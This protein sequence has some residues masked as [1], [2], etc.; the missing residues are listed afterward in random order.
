MLKINFIY[1]I[2]AFAVIVIMYL[3]MTHIHKDRRG[4]QSIFSGALF[5]T[6]KR[7]NIYVQKTAKTAECKWRPA[8]ICLSHNTFVTDKTFNLVKW[9]SNKYGF[10]TYIHYCEGYYS[11]EAVAK[12]LAIKEE[13]L[14]KNKDDNHSVYVETM[15]SPSYTSAISQSVQ[16]PGVSGMKNNLVLFDYE[17]TN[18]AELARIV[19][20]VSLVRAGDLHIGVFSFVKEIEYEENSVHVWIN[21]DRLKESNIMLLLAYIIYSN[22]DWKGADI[23][24]FDILRDDEKEVD[25]EFLKFIQESRLPISPNNIHFIKREEGDK[26]SDLVCRYSKGARF[27]ILGFETRVIK[28]IGEHV[29]DGYK[30]M[31]DILFINVDTSIEI[32]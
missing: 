25:T 13:I 4:L 15:I 5:Q 9:I 21:R 2:A 16:I 26:I 20:N 28:Q 6:L 30:E 14:Y 7:F 27:S 8:V 17:R 24:I 11:R 19:S 12:A 32:E 29:F 3:W 10:G 1:S 22:P 31:G 18:D 23:K